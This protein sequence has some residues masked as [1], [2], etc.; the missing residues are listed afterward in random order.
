MGLSGRAC[1]VPDM[2]PCLR[3]MLCGL[4]L[5]VGLAA[6]AQAVEFQ[7]I[8]FVSDTL[9]LTTNRL[10]VGAPMGPKTSDIGCPADAPLLIGDGISVTGIV[11]ASFFEGD[12]SR[13]SNLPSGVSSLVSLTDVSATTPA[14]NSL[15]RYNSG[16]SKWEAVGLNDGIST[17]TVLS[18]W[19]DAIVCQWGPPLAD[20][21]FYR[22]I[23]D[24]DDKQ[25][26][27]SNSGTG[28]SGQSIA[29]NGDKT[30][31]GT[32]YTGTLDCK[33]GAWSIADF[34]S[35]GRA[36][37]FLGNNGSQI[38]LTEIRDVSATAPTDGQALVW[39][40]AQARWIPGTVATSGGAGDRISTTDIASG[41][42]L[43]MVVASYGTVSFTTGGV[44]GTSYLNTAGRWIGPG[45]SITTAH[46][47][48]STNGYFAN[49][50]GIA[51]ANPSTTLTVSG[52]TYT[53][54]LHLELWPGAAVPVSVSTASGGGGA[55][56]AG[57]D[58]QVQFNDGGST[59]G[60]DSGLTFNK[61]TDELTV[62]GRVSSTKVVLANG[63]TD[64]CS[65]GSPV[66]TFRI[67]PADGY[68]EVCRPN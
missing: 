54:D 3:R 16:N 26:Y 63:S 42:G 2:L 1:K 21:T 7:S 45:I 9:G 49:R 22:G 11:S 13:L 46:G 38:S 64:T 51:T 50:L 23:S 20:W 14:D 30:W 36:F 32:S 17:T 8:V 4:T 5:S 43:G 15:L 40:N 47:I 57:A 39:N 18:G 10:C 27:F 6:H 66:G 48:S 41:A 60:A 58:T 34:Y 29:F 55:S 59:L 52:T 33:T 35:N 24:S 61:T 25:W 31:N 19:P 56:V 12:G 62:A 65:D 37:N 44:E 68:P 67:N 28:W 53:R